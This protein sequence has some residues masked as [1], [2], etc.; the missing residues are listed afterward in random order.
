MDNLLFDNLLGVC[1]WAHDV[2]CGQTGGARPIYTVPATAAPTAAPS[3]RPAETYPAPTYTAPIISSSTTTRPF[4]L[5]P[6][7]AARPPS[8][9]WQ[10]GVE[11]IPEYENVNNPSGIQGTPENGQNYPNQPPPSQ[12][13]LTPP[14]PPSYNPA[15]LPIY[16]NKEIYPGLT[17][18]LANPDRYECSKDNFYFAPNPTNCEQYFICENGRL[19]SHQCGPGIHWDY[20]YNQCDFAQTAFCYAPTSNPVN[21]ELP[22]F[23]AVT[24]PEST[25]VTVEETLPE[26]VAEPFFGKHYL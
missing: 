9:Q 11:G 1:N 21:V 18:S 17:L 22:Q 23:N 5:A 25:P 6:V 26:I 10:N 3:S 20:I 24:I 7:T 13:V 4:T 8:S 12:V 19:H 14:N 15:P 16:E 2:S